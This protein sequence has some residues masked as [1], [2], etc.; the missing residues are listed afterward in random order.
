MTERYGDLSEVQHPD[1]WALRRG[2][3]G[4]TRLAGAGEQIYALYASELLAPAILALGDPL[5]PRKVGG[6]DGGG[7]HDG[8]RRELHT[9]KWDAQKGMNPGEQVE[10]GYDSAGRIISLVL[11]R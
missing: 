7:L 8:Q 5:D 10:D 6:G 9:R 1:V 2:Q 11:A 4:K 3:P